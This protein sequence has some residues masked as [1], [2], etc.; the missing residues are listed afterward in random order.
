MLGDTDGRENADVPAGMA[1]FGQFIDHEIT[2]DPTSSLDRQNDPRALQNFRTPALDLDSIYG[3]GP[4]VRPFL[5]DERDPDEAKLLTGP[6]ADT[7]PSDGASTRAARFGATDLQ[8][9]GQDSALIVDPRNDENLL[10]SQLLLTVL[11]YHNRVVD[12]VRSGDGHHLIEAEEDAFE[13]AQRLVRWHYQWLVLH[14]FLEQVC[15]NTVIDDIYAH[16]REFFLDSDGPVS[17]P[18]EFAVAAYRYGHSQIR[19][20]YTVNGDS[21]DVQFFPGPAP[22]TMLTM[23]AGEEGPELPPGTMEEATEDHLQGFRAVPDDLVVEWPYFF[24]HGDGKTQRA[25]KI[26]AKL[27]PALHLLPF[28]SEGPTSLAV[29]NLR[30]GKAFGL[31]SGQALARAMDIDP[32]DND[33]LPLGNDRS[34]GEYL[35]DVHRGADTDAPAWLYV[36]AEADRQND[37]HRLGAVGSRIVGEVI[38]GLVEADDRTF[39]N[40]KPDWRPVLPREVTEVPDDE[41]ER[42]A[43]YRLGDLLRFATGPTPD[44]LTIEAVDADGSGPAPETPTADPTN[45][46]AVILEHTG[47]GEL[48]IDGYAVDY[49]EQRETITSEGVEPLPPLQPGERLAVYT[50]DGPDGDPGVRTVAFGRRAAAIDDGG[51]TVTVLTPTG[52]V[53]AFETHG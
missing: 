1:L 22:K 7:L 9:N 11:K 17:I 34:F 53:S 2:F 39:L 18:V 50:G 12:Y 46:E 21:G 31:P 48:P 42:A 30:R 23:A 33:D 43:P 32:I 24:E 19:D 6:A 28:I 27:P 8:R 52:E 20:A 26:D 14:E 4:E 44:G 35:A 51:E 40:E 13:A 16:G 37:G 49:E 47:A 41:S 25:A 45:G 15:D 3:T 5:Y 10:I 29:R 36:L 38:Y